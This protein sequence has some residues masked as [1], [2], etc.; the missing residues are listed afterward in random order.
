MSSINASAL[1]AFN[2]QMQSTP[3]NTDGGYD[4]WF[5]EDGV[6][7]CSVTS[8]FMK[9]C[10]APEW[11]ENEKVDHEGV[12]IK[13]TFQL[14]DDP[15]SP[16]SPRSFE[17]SPFILPVNGMD[18]FKTEQGQKKLVKTLGRLKGHLTVLLGMSECPDLHGS[19]GEIE[20]RLQTESIEARVKCSSWTSQ[21]N[22]TYN[23]EYV[24]SL[25][26]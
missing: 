22:K 24:N 1:S 20:S 6:Y 21:S 14:I 18:A 4:T 19:L 5:P 13:F 26:G 12:L 16:A 10:N 3:A 23:T 15:G 8:I 11:V 9:E 7:D 17:G 25:L 2:Q